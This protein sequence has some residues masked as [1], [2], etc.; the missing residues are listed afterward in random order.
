[1]P[2]VGEGKGSPSIFFVAIGCTTILFPFHPRLP[3]LGGGRRT[4]G[5]SSWE[6]MGD[7]RPLVPAFSPRCCAAVT[8][9]FQWLVSRQRHPLFRDLAI[10]SCWG[11]TQQILYF[12][13]IKSIRAAQWAVV[14]WWTSCMRIWWLL[15]ILTWFHPILGFHCWLFHFNFHFHF[16]SCLGKLIVF[17]LIPIQNGI[18]TWFLVIWFYFL[19]S[20]AREMD[21]CWVFSD[22]FVSDIWPS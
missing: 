16:H 2:E 9:T 10:V 13:R 12:F 7:C 5:A 1:M 15:L 6:R 18:S 4:D 21:V 8:M 14:N 11:N 22:V 3:H 19:W 20:V 17:G